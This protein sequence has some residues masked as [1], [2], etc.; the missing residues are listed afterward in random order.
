MSPSRVL[1]IVEKRLCNVLS[2][3]IESEYTERETGLC[4]VAHFNTVLNIFF[5]NPDFCKQLSKKEALGQASSDSEGE[6][7]PSSGSDTERPFHH[8]FQI[9]ERPASIVMNIRVS[10]YACSIS[11]DVR[12]PVTFCEHQTPRTDRWPLFCVDKAHGHL[13]C[14]NKHKL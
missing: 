3:V 10:V 5:V 14:R 7:H 8:P 11:M 13:F 1:T 6:E 2:P 12:L 4:C 9:K